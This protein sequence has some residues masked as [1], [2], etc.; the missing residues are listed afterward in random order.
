MF[1]CARAL[2]R[3]WVCERRQLRLGLLLWTSLL[4]PH[5]ALPDWSKSRKWLAWAYL[6]AFLWPPHLLV[7]Y[8]VPF[9]Y[10]VVLPNAK[11]LQRAV[12]HFLIACGDSD[13]SCDRFAPHDVETLDCICVISS[14]LSLTH[15]NFAILP[16]CFFIDPSFCFVVWAFFAEFSW[17]KRLPTLEACVFIVRIC[18]QVFGSQILPPMNVVLQFFCFPKNTSAV[19]PS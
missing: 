9:Q 4:P 3:V 12:A 2:A 17:K 13:V 14:S 6:L 5:F 11:L 16:W 7:S 15:R 18:D 8:V 10:P 19:L 1:L